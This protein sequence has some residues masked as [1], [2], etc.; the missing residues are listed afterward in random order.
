[1]AASG[2]LAVAG[3]AR[4]SPAAA[5]R[6]RAG[7]PWVYRSE[8]TLPAQA[9]G[10]SIV[11]V[12][13]VQGRRLA[14]AFWAASSPLALR[15][16]TRDDAEA[17]DS[18][19]FER[20]I[21][22]ALARRAALFPGFEAFRAVHGESDG[23]PG[24]IVDRFADGLTLQTT[25]EGMDQRKEQ[26]AALLQKRLGSR[27]VA[28]RDD[29]SARDFEGLPRE[30]R[31]L[32]GT[33]SAVSYREGENRFAI[34]LLTDHKTGSFLDQQENHLRAR[35][36]AR[37]RGLD[38]FSYHGGFALSLARGCTQVVAIEQDELAASRLA[39]NAKA[40]GLGHLEARCAN[41][42]DVFRDL[43]AA[44]ERFDI[45]VV[46]PPAFAK[47]KEGLDT[48]ARAYKE[49]FLRALRLLSPDGIL[50]ACSCSARFTASLL[51]SVVEEAAADVGRSL[52]LLERHGA[53]RDHPV[54]VGVPETG[55]LKCHVYR[56]L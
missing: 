30:K 56:A 25:A 6:V 15:V 10:G 46:D 4:I 3:E 11:S 48:A 8:V 23:L 39:A 38:T 28:L 43:E 45:V 12:A 14:R 24:L 19:F 44:K 7:L 40:N 20:R 47:R 5:K 34:D 54:L 55:Y 36:Y 51:D 27:V 31:L 29:G 33:D 9:A 17:I 42:F 52:Q 21:E 49:L 2:A 32:H 22:R 26:M 35:T 53:S 41:A 50:F 1:M 13:D 18:A 37:G 16:L